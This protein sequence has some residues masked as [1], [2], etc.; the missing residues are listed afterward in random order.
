MFSSFELSLSCLVLYLAGFLLN[1]EYM[2]AYF[3]RSCTNLCF[4]FLIVTEFVTLV[5]CLAV[6]IGPWCYGEISS[7]S[8][9]LR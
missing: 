9:Y 8:V 4:R 5:L 2:I 3:L 6:I 7:L 1:L